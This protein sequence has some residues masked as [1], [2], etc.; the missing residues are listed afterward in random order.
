[1]GRVDYAPRIDVDLQAGDIIRSI[2]GVKLSH[3]DDLRTELTKYKIGDAV[4]LEVERQGA[5]QFVT[6]ETE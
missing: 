1:V 2:N 6:F 3:V 4:A 5:F